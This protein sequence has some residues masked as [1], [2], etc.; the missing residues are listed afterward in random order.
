[1]R[2]FGAER[3]VFWR[4]SASG[5]NTL[6][7]FL[8]KDLSYIP[9]ML[10]APLLFEALFYSITAPRST[11]IDLYFILL[12]V[13]IVSV[14]LG[15]LVSIVVKPSV[16]QLTGVVIVMIMVMFSGM[17]PTLKEFENM[18]FPM[19]YV[20]WLSFP[21]WSQEAL[22]INGLSIFFLL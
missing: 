13:E 20:P 16:S 17:R 18:S 14:S 19:P 6:A 22:Y 15:F 11:F 5:I 12:C 21:R 9:N 3:V 2:I 4:E 7:Y 8:G 1:M 10:V